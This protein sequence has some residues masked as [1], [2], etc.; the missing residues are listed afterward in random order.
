MRGVAAVAALLMIG[1]SGCLGAEEDPETQSDGT[2]SS[3]TATANAT[4]ATISCTSSST[5][6]GGNS[7][8]A[9]GASSGNATGNSTSGP[10]GNGTAG[11]NSTVGGNATGN[12]TGNQTAS[13]EVVQTLEC[14]V[15]QGIPLAAGGARLGGNGGN[16]G[17]GGCLTPT[18]GQDSILVAVSYGAECFSDPASAIGDAFAEGDSFNIYCSEDVTDTDVSMDFAAA[19]AA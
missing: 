2:G 12:A 16:P 15:L 18:L 9:S 17:L 1:V 5:G 19:P 13:M 11:G 6:S 3:C 14:W 4:A 7:T 10:A 8:G